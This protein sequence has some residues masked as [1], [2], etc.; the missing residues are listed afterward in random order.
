MS[1]VG[2]IAN[3][4]SGKDIRRLVAYGSVFDNHEKVHILRRVLIGLQA[5]GVEKVLFMPD[6][7]GMG[8][9]AID[10][11]KLSLEATTL[12]M[13]FRGTEKDSTEA[14]ARFREMQVDCIVTLGGDGTN[15]AVA[16]EC[17]EI[18]LLPI[19]TGT[20]NVFPYMIEGSIA[21]LAAGVVASQIVQWDHVVRPTKRLEIEKNGRLVDIA[22]I[23][24]AVYDDLFLGSRAIWDISKIREIVLTRA[25][26]SHIGLSSI[27]GCLYPDA[28]NERQGVYIKVGSGAREI[29]AP[30]APG[31]MVR[32]S[33]ESSRLIDL[34]QRIEVKQ[35]PSVLALDGERELEVGE[36]DCISIRLTRDGPWLIDIKRALEEA[37]RR[38]FFESRP[39]NVKEEVHS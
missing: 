23:D 28:L 3:P 17:R 15:R 16:K 31:L 1:K 32:V 25:D 22:L 26:L 37:A 5:S 39:L 13:P 9:R 12:Q 7:F 6:T 18:P 34:N 8:E 21:G 19:S 27:G 11:V 4:A 10:G 20:N 29:L 30:I 36:E 2:I 14:A 35:K 38:G 24:A 33:I